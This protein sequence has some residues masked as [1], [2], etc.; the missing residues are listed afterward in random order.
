[1]RIEVLARIL[2][3]HFW[4]RNHVHCGSDF[5]VLNVLRVLGGKPAKAANVTTTLS[6]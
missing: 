5:H 1:M 6:A 4:V 2:L 3:K